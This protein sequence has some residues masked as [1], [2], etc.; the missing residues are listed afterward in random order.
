VAGL[1]AALVYQ[2]Y[3]MFPY[4]PLARKQVQAHKAGLT[5]STFSLLFANVL[6]PNRN[7]KRLREIISEADPDIILTV[8]TDDWWKTAL[9]PFE[10]THP[11]TVLRPQNNTYGMMLYSRLELIDA[12]VKFLVQDDIPSIHG[13]VRLPSGLEVELR[14]LHPRPPF[15]TEDEKST[16]RD[17]ELLIVGKESKKLDRPIIVMGDLN[18]VAWS[19]TNYLFQDISGLLDPRIG[20]GFYHTF[21]AKLPLIR[22]PLD[23]FFHSNHFRL[24]DFKRLDYFGSDHFPVYIKLSYEPDAEKE[25]QQLRASEAEKQE[26]EEK[27]EKAVSDPSGRVDH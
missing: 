20:R 22:F 17:A 23:H 13:R 27:I 1:S 14:C 8:E 25:Q 16:E 18:D 12:E 2:A 9:A 15:P 3:M 5:E 26:A 7:A 24:V 19:R 4:T 6:M 10:E 11:Y 21:H